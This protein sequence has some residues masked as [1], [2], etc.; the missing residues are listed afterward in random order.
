M[1]FTSVYNDK[2]F[3]NHA[4]CRNK[5]IGKLSNKAL[6]HQ[7]SFIHPS[8]KSFN[9]EEEFMDEREKTFQFILDDADKNYPFHIVGHVTVPEVFRYKNKFLIEIFL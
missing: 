9:T 8:R 1:M 6:K 5:Y 2:F 4:P 3:I 7:Q